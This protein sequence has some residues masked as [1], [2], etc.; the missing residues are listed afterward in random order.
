MQ[1]FVVAETSIDRR[2]IKAVKDKS[3]FRLIADASED[4]IFAV[5]YPIYQP[6]EYSVN[7]AFLNGNA[8]WHRW[9]LF[10]YLAWNCEKLSWQQ[11]SNI[12]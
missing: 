2:Y 10:Q 5:T 4:M 12:K 3:E 9:D 6:K 8:D 1:L 11:D 7:L